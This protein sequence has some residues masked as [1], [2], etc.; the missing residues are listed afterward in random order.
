MSTVA[1]TASTATQ[2][3]SVTSSSS[4][5]S[6]STT[7]SSATTNSTTG[8]TTTNGLVSGID[9]DSII[10][11]TM[12]VARLPEQLLQ[13]KKTALNDKVTA[14]QD[15]NTLMLSLNNAAS[16][17]SSA[18]TYKAKSVSSSD[19]TILSGL[20]TT[21]A[22]AGQY[23]ITVN[24]LA[25]AQQKI[26][27]GYSDTSTATVGTGKL[28][29]KVGSGT[30]VDVTIDSTN[31]TLTGLANSINSANA[32]VT[33]SIVNDGSSTN[34]YHLMITSNT[35]GT[36]GQVTITSTLS[37]GTSP[38]F[39][40]MQAAS[41]ASV[42]IGQ[43]TGAI[44]V[45]GNS[46]TMANVI[47]GVTLYLQSANKDKSITLDV[48]PNTSQIGSDIATWIDSYN[49]LMDSM[50][51][52]FTYDSTNQTS[53]AL[54]ADTMLET[55]QTQLQSMISTQ[56]SGAA[57][58]ASLLSQVGITVDSSNNH[59]VMTATTLAGF[60]TDGG[61]KIE[62]LFSDVGT[63]TNNAVTFVSNTENTKATGTDGYAI[64]ITQAA[65]HAHLTAGAAQTSAL[66]ADETLTVNG[67]AISLTA[68]MTQNQVIS[69]INA[70]SSTTGVAASATG[71]DGTGSGNYLTFTSIGFGSSGKISVQSALSNGGTTPTTDT[72]GIGNVAVTQASGLGESG[73]GT[74]SAGLDV[75]GTINGEEASGTGQILTGKYANSNTSGLVLK[76]TA[77][78]AGTYGAVH[79]SKGIASIMHDFTS[80]VTNS[81]YGMITMTETNLKS[82]SS[83]IDTQ[84]TTME[85]Q[86][87]VQ[88]DNLVTK[89][90][91]MESS[92]SSLK[93]Q[94]AYIKEFFQVKDT[95]S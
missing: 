82:Q 75:A 7:K 46:N 81:T 23:S 87:T 14:W 21:S 94:L 55:M 33:A 45:T 10:T 83:D 93:N 53:P 29:L 12:A 36:A 3:S 35:T 91:N 74:A 60:L 92:L 30:A 13:D 65:T 84:I 59:L 34:N 57:N 58:D 47:P 51:S 77:T 70:Y 4:S 41:D 8:T 16:A 56:V 39:G 85:A 31:N 40:E 86:L 27:Q 1:N 62:K 22:S 78:Q 71:A 6:S 2:A 61:N 54:F 9:I 79:I 19:T 11:K 42:T 18:D 32:G 73:T 48:S 76:I 24:S 68:G 43:G 88:Q 44:T 49:N 15:I 52:Q 66:A 25:A 20:A 63:S 26:S 67:Q 90:S 69:A 28:T 5:S 50:T 37:G 95:S 80:S 38:T 72:S 64:V 17:L 89:Y